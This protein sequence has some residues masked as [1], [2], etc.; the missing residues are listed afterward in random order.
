MPAV[1]CLDCLSFFFSTAL[2][3]TRFKGFALD[4]GHQSP[5]LSSVARA[6]IISCKPTVAEET[7]L[8]LYNF[9]PCQIAGSS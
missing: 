2:E 1:T 3:K 4:G 6:K 5:P 9:A 8:L 7:R